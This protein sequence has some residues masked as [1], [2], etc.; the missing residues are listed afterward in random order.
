MNAILESILRQQQPS[1][2]QRQ[3][4]M[5]PLPPI[6]QQPSMMDPYVDSS[7]GGGNDPVNQDNRTPDQMYSDAIA[8]NKS[9]V[10]GMPVVGMPI[11]LMNNAFI[12]DYEKK[13]PDKAVK[14]PNRM[15]RSLFDQMMDAL[16]GRTNTSPFGANNIGA[17]PQRSNFGNY[18]DAFGGGPN[19]DIG[20]SVDTTD[21]SPSVGVGDTGTAVA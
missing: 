19:A 7:N 21:Q 1:M 14:D 4:N 18:G 5:P 2:V 3:A 6:P 12:T 16:T 20:G 10:V 9:P 11:G 15:Y 13:N 17:F 8:M